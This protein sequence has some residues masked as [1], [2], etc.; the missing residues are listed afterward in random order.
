MAQAQ[1]SPRIASPQTPTNKEQLVQV[2]DWLLPS[3]SIFAEMTL[4]GNTQWLPLS[5]VSL[6]LLWAWSE[7]RHLTDAFAYAKRDCGKLGHVDLPATYQGMMKALVAHNQVLMTILCRVLRQRMEAIGGRLFRWHGWVLIAFD[8]SRS[9]TPRTPANEKAF[10]AAHH[11][12][13]KTAKYR[14]KK[15]KGMRRQK[16]EKNQ[17][18]PPVPQM[19][20]TLLWHVGLRL[21]WAWRLGPSNSSERGHAMDMIQ[22]EDF[23]RKTLFCGDAG[24]VGYD[25]W[26]SILD[27]GNQ[28]LVRVGAN[29]HLLTQSVRYHRVGESQVLCWPK[30]K[31]QK[32]CPPL[33]LRL[34]KIRV[35]KTK[36]FLLTSVLQP[37][38]LSREQV[39][40]C[41]QLRWGVEVE[42]RGLKQ[43]LDR[44]K[45]RCRNDARAH[46][47]MHWSM[48]GMA[49]A[50]LLALKEQLQPRARTK[51][52]RAPD[53][54]R[55]SL[56]Q[57][58]RALRTCL[59]EIDD[60]P[61]AGEDL[62]SQLAQALI[63]DYQRTS[64][65]KARYRPPNPDKKPL[66][67]PSI[68]K[69]DGEQRKKLGKGNS[70]MAT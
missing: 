20:I 61:K 9:S 16:N 26:K 3:Q 40:R 21:P 53:P 52:R 30:D 54:N 2:L 33:R 57:T 35:G 58:M 43:T 28:F 39:A 59:R 64:S 70:R 44:A 38:R 68:N 36:M 19:W 24:F 49:M 32:G 1:R 34:V 5:L 60:V 47:E 63:D 14:K 45:L 11:G 66:G 55:R 41:Y 15:T 6:A 50:E 17:P 13:G 8:G 29:V 23:P 56:A 37:R 22:N 31:M 42:F 18:A 12:Q 51:R 10:C 25:F 46:V 4:H 7:A 65:K 48:L 27:R 67:A 62:I 69:L